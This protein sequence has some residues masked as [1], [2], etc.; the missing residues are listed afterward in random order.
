MRLPSD[1]S[2]AEASLSLLDEA[3]SSKSSY[4]GSCDIVG[5]GHGKVVEVE[6]IERRRKRP[7]VK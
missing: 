7:Y 2:S 1:T 6:K 3:E 5:L 4:S